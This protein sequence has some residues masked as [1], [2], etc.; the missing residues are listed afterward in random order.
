MWL[1]YES[2]ESKIFITLTT[3]INDKLTKM[4]VVLKVGKTSLM[5]FST[6]SDITKM[7]SPFLGGLNGDER[8]II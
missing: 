8:E 7:T 2:K 3:M 5:N 6:F 1:I 4:K